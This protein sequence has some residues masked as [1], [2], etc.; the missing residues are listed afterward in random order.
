MWINEIA[1]IFPSKFF[2]F[3]NLLFIMKKIKLFALASLFLAGAFLTKSDAQIDAT[4]NPIGALFGNFNV[5]ADFGITESIS[6]EMAVG[7]SSGD[8]DG[9]GWN[10]FPITAIG[11]YYFNPNRGVDKFYADAFVRF[12]NRNLDAFDAMGGA[13][14]TRFG[15]GFG[16]GYKVVG[17]SGFVF[18]IG[19]G[20][21]R[22]IVDKVKYDNEADTYDID[23][24]NVMVNGKLGIGYRFGGGK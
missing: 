21:G 2:T 1:I 15:V 18:D 11:K 17:N 9:Q 16:L 5:G 7:F 10:S 19:V 13:S 4:I 6:L 24:L 22:A 8:L 3:L 23:W 20:V 12:V 14:Y